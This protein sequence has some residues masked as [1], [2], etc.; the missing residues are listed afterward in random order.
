MQHVLT[1]PGIADCPAGAII[2]WYKQVGDRVH[3]GEP[4]LEIRFTSP[5]QQKLRLNKTIT[6]RPPASLTHPLLSLTPIDTRSQLTIRATTAV[7]RTM[8]MVVAADIT[9]VLQA[10]VVPI[11]QPIQAGVIIARFTTEK[12]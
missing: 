11:G 5:A 1:M 8:Q 7:A 2:R 6:Q 4:L 9:G 10:I 12:P 3:P